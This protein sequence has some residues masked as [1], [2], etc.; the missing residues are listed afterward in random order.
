LAARMTYFTRIP[1][2]RLK[3]VPTETRSWA[4]PVAFTKSIFNAVKNCKFAD[5]LKAVTWAKSILSIAQFTIA[6][7]TFSLSRGHEGTPL[8]EH[9]VTI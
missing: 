9:A 7:C 3:M 4:R 8:N 6:I 1:P 5:A 2:T